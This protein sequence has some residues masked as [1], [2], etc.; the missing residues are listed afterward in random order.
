MSGD[1]FTVDPQDESR[2]CAVRVTSSKWL[3]QRRGRPEQL[4][5]DVV[6]Q[7]REPAP[8]RRKDCKA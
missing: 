2:T 3:G 5:Q 8:A 4:R 1:D 6:Q 7:D